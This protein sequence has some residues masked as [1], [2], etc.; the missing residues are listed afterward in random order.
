MEERIQK[1]IA[2]AGIA[3]RRHAE[4]MIT[5]GLVT[6]NGT[7]ITEL[8][9]KADESRDH[10]KV[11]GK[12]LQPRKGLVYLLLHKPPEV[13]STMSDP[14]GRSSLLDLLHGVS[15]RVFPV[16]RLEYHSAGLVFLT[17]DGDLA[18]LVLRS[19]RVRQTYHLK[20]KTL[21]TFEE[22]ETLGRATGAHIERIRGKESPWYIVTL[23][24]A[25]S[26][27]LRDKL[28]QTGHPVEKIRRVGIANLELGSL[29]SGTYRELTS[30]E[31]AAFRRAI[32]TGEN[33]ADTDSKRSHKPAGKFASHSASPRTGS[34]N[35]WRD[36]QRSGKN[37]S[38]SGAPRSARGTLP[39]NLFH[40]PGGTDS[41]NSVPGLHHGQG[42]AP[43]RTFG[44]NPRGNQP[45]PPFER[46]AHDKPPRNPFFRPGQQ[47]AG[48]GPL[49]NMPQ[50][51][52]R[53]NGPPNASYITPRIERKNVP[54]MGRTESQGA[55]PRTGPSNP[56]YGSHGNRPQNDSRNS[57]GAGQHKRQGSPPRDGERNSR[58]DSRRTGAPHQ[59][60]APHQRAPRTGPH[61]PGGHKNNP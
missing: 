33:S 32:A 56:R 3:S 41:R 40:V 60:R 12:L 49:S 23:S 28:F 18:N 44:K 55:P 11:A 14:E 50:T 47:G 57:A 25:R 45:R 58:S 21:L 30:T 29:A 1:I 17:N 6:V 13:V 37:A 53:R 5:S 43:P 10:I 39:G 36:R 48:R 61:K 59:R 24:E 52:P 7:T 16:G 19:H 31:L 22:I 4:E 54:P 51:P 20:L 15:E 26:D 46:A 42:N 27:A 8:G 35:S 2:R 38:S 34:R 9:S